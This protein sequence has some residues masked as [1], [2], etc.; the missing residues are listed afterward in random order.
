MKLVEEDLDPI[1]LP[2]PDRLRK[3]G[4]AHTLNNYLHLYGLGTCQAD[5][6]VYEPC[7]E[8]RGI[9]NDEASPDDSAV[10]ES[11]KGL[12]LTWSC[13]LW[14]LWVEGTEEDPFYDEQNGTNT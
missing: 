13:P 6:P 4:I 7:Q 11:V 14:V 2:K 12:A 10:L 9:M 5:C 1:N 3:A 8:M